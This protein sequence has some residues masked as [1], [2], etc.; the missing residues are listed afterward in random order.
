MVEVESGSV[1]LMSKRPRMLN[2]TAIKSVLT[3]DTEYLILFVICIS[4]QIGKRSA[5]GQLAG[6][7]AVV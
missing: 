6:T 2:F 3:S 1:A 7:S 5:E 4:L